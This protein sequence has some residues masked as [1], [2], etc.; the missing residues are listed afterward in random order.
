MSA[1]MLNLNL[2]SYLNIFNNIQTLLNNWKKQL[3]TV[4]TNCE[5]KEPHLEQL[6]YQNFFEHNTKEMKTA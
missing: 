1:V 3:Q 2:S 4:A 5:Q 6:Q